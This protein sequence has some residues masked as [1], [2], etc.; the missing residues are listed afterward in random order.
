MT[1]TVAVTVFMDVTDSDG[2]RLTVKVIMY[3]NRLNEHGSG[4][5]QFIRHRMPSLPLTALFG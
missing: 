2:D 5:G 4:I 3:L 1:M